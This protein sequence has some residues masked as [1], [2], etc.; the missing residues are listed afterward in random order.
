MRLKNL[1]LEALNTFRVVAELASFTEAAKLLCISQSAVSK[2]VK[3]FE[4]SLDVKLFDRLHHGL[5]LTAQGGLLLK[6]IEQPLN[7]IEVALSTMASTKDQR[8]LRVL[9]PPTL[10]ARNLVPQLKKFNKQFPGINIEV[11]SSMSSD[12]DLENLSSKWD[13]VLAYFKN[14]VNDDQYQCIRMERHIVVSSPSLWVDGYPPSVYSS[15]LLHMSN[16]THN[17]SESWVDWFNTMDAKVME[18]TQKG[19]YFQTLEQVIQAAILG[20]G[21]ALIDESM[22]IKELETGSLVKV[23]EHYTEGPYGYWLADF[24]AN[25]KKSDLEH[26]LFRNLLERAA[27]NISCSKSL[28]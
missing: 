22:I 26:L 7:S 3:S 17:P 9:A 27:G 15:T 13:F 14:P 1:H 6:H 25:T 10:I 5:K 4:E 24:R 28:M 20:I 12:V 21:I 2:Q 18:I 11:G 19:I 23:S 8:S 16:S